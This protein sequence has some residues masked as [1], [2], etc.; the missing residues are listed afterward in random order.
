[1][2]RRSGVVLQSSFSTR[3]MCTRWYRDLIRRL[4]PIGLDE[5]GLEAALEQYVDD[6]R[7]RLPQVQL[8]LSLEGDLDALERRMRSRSTAC[9]RRGMTNVSE[10]R[11]R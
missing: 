1:M 7:R 2:S 11:G 3:T 8:R 10:A 4:R 5:L 9:S 6:W